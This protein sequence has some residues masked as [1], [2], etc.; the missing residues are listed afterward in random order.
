[1]YLE[2]GLQVISVCEIAALD[3]GSVVSPGIDPGY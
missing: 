2:E 3:E 1:M